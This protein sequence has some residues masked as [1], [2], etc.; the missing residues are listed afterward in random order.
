MPAVYLMDEAQTAAADAPRA[1]V[2]RFDVIHKYIVEDSDLLFSKWVGRYSI[3]MENLGQ[4]D[5]DLVVL[6]LPIWRAQILLRSRVIAAFRKLRILT[7][8]SVH[9]PHDGR[10]G[11]IPFELSALSRLSLNVKTQDES[12]DTHCLHSRL[13]VAI[14]ELERHS[15]CIYIWRCRHERGPAGGVLRAA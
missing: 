4:H 15:G 12:S 8:L 14:H 2:W 13:L 9:E 5:A 3:S 10:V 6:F 7:V 11:F 1:F